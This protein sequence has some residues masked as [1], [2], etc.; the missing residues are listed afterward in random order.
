MRDVVVRREARVEAALLG[1]LAAVVGLLALVTAAGPGLLDRWA[2]DALRSRLAV[3]RQDGTG[4]THSLDLLRDDAVPAPDPSRS[5]LGRDLAATGDV[6]LKAAKPPLRGMLA[7][8]STRIEVPALRATSAAGRLQVGLLYADDAPAAG[9]YAQGAPPGPATATSSVPVAF[10]TAARDALHLTLGQR[11]HL[12]RDIG[13]DD[14]D[15]V[16]SGFFTPPA[17]ATAPLW[18][19]ETLLAHPA[20]TG[21]LWRAQAV[22]DAASIDALQQLS[23]GTGDAV[24]VVWRTSLRMTPGQATRFATPGGLRTL[25]DAVDTY[26]AAVADAYC[27]GAE[28]Y[29][30]GPCRTGRHPTSTLATTDGVPGVLAPFARAREQA[31]TLESFALAGLVAVG[32]ATVAVTAR[33]AVHRRAAAQALQRARGA[34]ATDLALGRLLQTAPA[35]LLGAA[36]GLGA[37]A[38]VTPGGTGSLLPGLLVAAAAWLALPALTL[39]AARDRRGRAARPPAARRLVA[40]GAVL[41]LAAVGVLVLRAHGAGAG[42]LDVQLAVVPALL[43]AAAVVLLVRLYP[44]PLRLLSH[45]ARGR[46]GTVPLIAF[47]RAAREAPGHA[48]ALLVLVMTLSTAVFGGLVSR[49]VADG[50]ATAAVWSAGADAAVIGAGR[51]GRADPALAGVQGVTRATAVRSLVV[52][53][54]SAA[55]GARFDATRIAGLDAAAVGAAA[56]D[57][58]AARALAA[59]HLA[60]RPA[61][62]P[63]GGRYVLPALATGDFADGRTGGTYTTTLR[64]G[65][66]SIRVVGRLPDAARRDPALGPLLSVYQHDAGRGESGTGST[67]VAT[68]SPLLLVDAGALAMLKASEFSDAAVL[69]YGPHLDADEL[70]ATAPRLTGPTGQVRVK[71]AELALASHDGLLRGVRRTYAA[72]TGLAVLLALLALLLDLLLSARDRGRTASRLR[73]LGL[74]TRGIAALNVL[75]LLPV[76]LAAVAGGVTLGLLLPGILGPALTL[77]EFTGGPA[78][79]ALHTDYALTAALGAGLAALVAA[80]VALETWAGRRRGLGAV[81]R[82]GEAV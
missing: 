4:I 12:S 29:M 15:A 14:T 20:R 78:A 24:T 60:G 45:A 28:D 37:A 58:A 17:G 66:V 74:P 10:S 44:L 21:G 8:D 69:L 54:T 64:H 22:I 48:L 47:S 5:T 73:T 30:A 67:A 62:Q 77:R 55:D 72:G 65:T 46:P 38:L 49:T 56:P 32:L 76:A 57:S 39:A 61:P 35:A 13:S 11:L 63:A 59:A 25:Q 7:H 81:L 70:R 18:H 26:S 6:L 2:G 68:G 53:L 79:P 33:L 3:A 80:A 1:C 40:E 41:L 71:A 43:G 36:L 51:D 23:R 31:R 82:L 9:S 16:V 42:G 19:E 75:E 34:S 50:G 52:Q 27:P